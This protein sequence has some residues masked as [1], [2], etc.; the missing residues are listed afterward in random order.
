MRVLLRDKSNDPE[1]VIQSKNARE[2]NERKFIGEKRMLPGPLQER[3]ASELISRM[4]EG[5]VVRNLGHCEN[6]FV[7]IVISVG[8]NVRFTRLPHA[9]NAC[10][11]TD[12][13][14]ELGSI[15]TLSNIEHPKN[16]LGPIDVTVTGSRIDTTFLAQE[17]VNR[18]V[19]IVVMLVH[20]DK[21]RDPD[22]P[23]Q[24]AKVCAVPGPMEVRYKGE[25]TLMIPEI[26]D[27]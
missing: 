21:S 10:V 2:P 12:V 23:A 27:A 25:G 18:F 4:L 1:T 20:A 7:P 14:C 16:A 22:N 24:A 13:I 9:K 8:G 5:K 19:N 3:N 6:A 11:S 15:H 17:P 26:V